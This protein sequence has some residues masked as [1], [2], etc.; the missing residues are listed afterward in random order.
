M[1]WFL[2]V[3]DLGDGDGLEFDDVVER[4]EQVTGADEAVLVAEVTVLGPIER[5]G[6]SRWVDGVKDAP[7]E[8]SALELKHPAK[9]SPTHKE[10]YP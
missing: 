5:G 8:D 9:V 3:F 1:R 7:Q 6:D 2:G 4:N 10:V